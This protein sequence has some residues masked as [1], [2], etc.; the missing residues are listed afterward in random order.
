MKRLIGLLVAVLMITALASCSTVTI[1]NSAE[2][3]KKLEKLGYVVNVSVQYGDKV[4]AYN[5]KQVTKLTADKGDDFVEVYFFTSE[6]DTNNFYDMKAKSFSSG[7][8]VVKKNTYSIYRG[9]QKAVD[10]FLG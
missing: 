1:P 10:D 7:V 2:A 9:T 3:Q 4:S 6:E 5:V 8:E